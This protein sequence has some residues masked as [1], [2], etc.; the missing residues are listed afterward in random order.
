MLL[1]VLHTPPILYKPITNMSSYC[2]DVTKSTPYQVTEDLACRR[3]I[4][5]ILNPYSG[6]NQQP[7]DTSFRPLLS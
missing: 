1:S 4:S 7:R 2:L 5:E 3:P 6:T